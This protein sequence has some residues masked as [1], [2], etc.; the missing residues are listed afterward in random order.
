MGVATSMEP[1][2]SIQL[3]HG[4]VVQVHGGSLQLG[5][6]WWTALLVRTEFSMVDGVGL[7]QGG[8]LVVTPFTSVMRTPTSSWSTVA[9][10][11]TSRMQSLCRS[12]KGVAMNIA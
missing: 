10:L 9:P 6:V 7:V 11:G 5:S 12:P 8:W 3:L 4:S 1:A 2:L